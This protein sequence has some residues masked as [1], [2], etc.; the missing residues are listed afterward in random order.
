MRLIS[1]V[2]II[3]LVLLVPMYFFTKWWVVQYRDK[4]DARMSKWKIV[5]AIKGSKLF[6]LYNKFSHL[7]D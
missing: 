7:G 5:H 4:I 2:S 6:Q 3:A 1:T